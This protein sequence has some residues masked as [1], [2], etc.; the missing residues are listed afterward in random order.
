MDESPFRFQ[1]QYEDNIAVLELDHGKANE[2]G[3]AQI[4]AWEALIEDLR[5]SELRALVTTSRRVSARGNPIFIAGANVTERAGWTNAEVAA[6][7]K[8]QREMLVALRRL[9]LFHVAV[10]NG[11]ALGWGTEFLLTC[12]YRIGARAATF[13]L[14][15][16]GLGII[17]GAGGSAELWS[18]VGVNQALRLGMTGEIIRAEEAR[19]IGLIEEITETPE[20]G[21][22]RAVALAKLVARRSPT[23]VAAFKSAVLGAVGRPAEDR[24][25]LEARAYRLCL[26]S[27][28]AAIGRENFAAI[29]HGGEAPWG[30]RREL[31]DED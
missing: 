27:G 13:G 8:R 23:A 25:A 11:V 10:V 18:V 29:T 7:V 9:P 15:E 28:E 17:P 2:M 12:D 1:L 3:V 4:D 31:L 22:E 24:Q 14:P 21:V 5:N 19:R 26:E 6:H 30:F 16:T 20:E